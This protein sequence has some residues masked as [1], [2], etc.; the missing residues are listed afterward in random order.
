[1]KTFI[2]KIITKLK[3]EIKNPQGEVVENIVKRLSISSD[4]KV[5]TGKFYE[6]KIIDENRNI[7]DEKIEKISKEILTNPLIE[8]FEIISIEEYRWKLVL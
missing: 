8:T 5:N 4:L 1:M 3:E 7:A 6:I 2:Y